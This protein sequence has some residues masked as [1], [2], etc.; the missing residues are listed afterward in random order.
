MFFVKTSTPI[1]SMH[2]KLTG[3]LYA[4]QPSPESLVN[5]MDNSNLIIS[6]WCIRG[7]TFFNSLRVKL[8]LAPLGMPK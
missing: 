5:V 8:I 6:L 4:K 1:T 2:Q 7:A 3:V